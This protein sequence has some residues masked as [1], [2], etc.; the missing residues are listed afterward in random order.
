MCKCSAGQETPNHV[1]NASPLYGAP[2]RERS[3]AELDLV[4]CEWLLDDRLL[5]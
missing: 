2:N 4:I 1:I 3:I 5:I